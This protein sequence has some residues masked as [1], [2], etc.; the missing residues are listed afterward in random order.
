MQTIFMVGEQRS[1]SN[2]LRLILNESGIVAGPHPPH[3]LQRML[4][5]LDIYGNLNDER[6]F[7]RLVEDVCR[8]V[9][10]NPVPWEGIMFDRED[11][12]RRCRRNSL[13][14]VYGAVMEI[15]AETQ[16]ASAWI[17]KSMQNIRWADE[18]NA[19]FD[20]PK[21]IYLYRDPRD[22]TLSFTKAVIGD[23][24]PYF[25]SQQWTELQNL[26]LAQRDQLGPES[27][28]SLCYEDLTSKPEQVVNELCDFLGIKFSTRMLSFY[29][30]GEAERSA[31]S[32]QLWENLTKP[33][34][35]SNSKKFLKEL[36]EDEIRIIESVAGNVMDVLGYER[37]HVQPGAEL[38]FTEQELHEFKRE[39]E[40]RMQA[41]S[42]TA[43]PE[44]LQRR[45]QQSSFLA[46]IRAMAS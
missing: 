10:L 21:Y 29:N 1:G 40:R 31:N 30:S 12:R 8:L 15:Y 25:I 34:D 28:F 20:K 37:V 33:I 38:K 16:Q 41:L 9:E 18:L 3:I 6:N 14:A 24:H 43:N 27:F 44:D 23:K 5:L 11:V 46:Q 39:N 42:K 4:P 7:S 22:V 32:S 2:L 36:S 45:R 19:Y 26:C 17:C 35:S 13:I